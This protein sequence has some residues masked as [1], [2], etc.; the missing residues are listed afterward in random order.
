MSKYKFNSLSKFFIVNVLTIMYQISL[1]L[2]Q[3]Y[4]YNG[5]K[6]YFANNF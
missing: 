5:E 4:K 2:K 3:A 6:I 1:V